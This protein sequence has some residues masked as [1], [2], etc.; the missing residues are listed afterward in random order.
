MK[1]LMPA[2]LLATALTLPVASMATPKASNNKPLNTAAATQLVNKILSG[3]GTIVQTFPAANNL[4]G[5]VVR[6]AQGDNGIV[7]ADAKGQ[8]LFVG[9]VINAQGQ[10][11]T[12]LFTNQYINSKIAGPAY[13]E[14]VNRAWF[15]DGQDNA[16]HKAYILIDP[17]CIFCNLLYKQVAP[18]IANGQLQVRWIPVAFRDPSSP[19]K[20]AALLN[21]GSDEAAD[22]LLAQ[23]EDG[24]NNQTESGALVPLAANA[25]DPAVT[26]AFTKVTQNTAYFSHFGFQG[27]PTILYKQADGKVMMVPGLPRGQAFQD[28]ITSMGSSW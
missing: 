26:A 1:I 27:T 5:F 24:F 19:G 9:S 14:A 3:Q 2:V 16:P 4:I 13:Q 21:A 23:N 28:M 12:Q 20:A 17:N 7:Y 25:N 22:K 15:A 10:D 11:L 8:Y 6:S 18:L